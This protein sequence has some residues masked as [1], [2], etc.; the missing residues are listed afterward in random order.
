MLHCFGRGAASCG[1][2]SGRRDQF[3]VSYHYRL[4]HDNVGAHL[5][6]KS[7]VWQSTEDGLVQNFEIP[8]SDWFQHLILG[9]LRAVNIV[10][11]SAY[12]EKFLKINDAKLMQDHVNQTLFSDFW[13]H[14]TEYY[15]QSDFDEEEDEKY[16][17]VYEDKYKAKVTTRWKGA[18]TWQV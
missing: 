2:C 15:N 5:P 9:Q 13:K 6:L 17:M 14:V 16:T 10:F 4:D 7:I 18:T 8:W 12:Y 1:I 11:S 3:R